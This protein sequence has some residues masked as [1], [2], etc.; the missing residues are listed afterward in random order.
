MLRDY[1]A[2]QLI[3]SSLTTATD[4]QFTHRSQ[5]STETTKTGPVNTVAQHI[6]CINI[7]AAA[8]LDPVF[9]LNVLSIYGTAYLLIVL[10]LSLCLHSRIP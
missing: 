6:N 1:P 2:R 9:S 3:N 7:L 8:Q 4:R 5:L 10:A